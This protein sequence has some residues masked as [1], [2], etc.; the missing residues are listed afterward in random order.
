MP[1]LNRYRRIWAYLPPDYDSLPNK[2]YPVIYMHDGQNLFDEATSFAGEW[3]VDEALEELGY[4][5][6]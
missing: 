4:G 3:R 5:R 6:G 2:R 1:Q